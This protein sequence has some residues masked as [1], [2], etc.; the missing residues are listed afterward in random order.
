MR[1]D[2]CVPLWKYHQLAYCRPCWTYASACC[3]LYGCHHGSC[4]R[5]HHCQYLSTHRFAKRGWSSCLLSLLA[6]GL[7]FID[8]RCHL[9][10]L[11]FRDISNSPARKG[12][13][14]ICFGSFCRNH[15]LLTVCAN[16]LCSYWLEVLPSFHRLYD[17]DWHFHMVLLSRGKIS[18]CFPF[19]H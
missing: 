19:W 12:P 9:L 1:L 6:H 10:H 5:V 7:L 3:W 18:S 17:R 4:W 11:C 8:F 2:Y 13:C 14:S 15:H 16:C